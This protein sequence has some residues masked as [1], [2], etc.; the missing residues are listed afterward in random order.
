MWSHA[1]QLSD[2]LL[3]HSSFPSFV[4]CVASVCALA[5][6]MSKL[7]ADIEKIVP[8][9]P[10]DK[11]L[12]SGYSSDEFYE[13][14]HKLGAEGRGIY[15]K[16]NLLDFIVPWPAAAAVAII[17]GPLFTKAGLWP[18]ANL[19]PLL[20]LAVDLSENIAIRFAMKSF[21]AQHP[22]VAFL[23]GRLTQCN[24]L[25]RFPMLGAIVFGGLYLAWQWPLSS[26]H[27][28]HTALHT[29]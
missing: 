1:V 29:D 5:Y 15:L 4:V 28:P 9:T 16:L 2:V 17:I 22:A 6:R 7:E 3:R 19:L 21:P 23:A 18:R 27:K 26:M 25:M 11:R 24:F 8:F 13:L 20:F 12:I 14:M 10:L